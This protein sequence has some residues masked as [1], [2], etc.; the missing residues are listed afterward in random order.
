M[1]DL[2][3]KYKNTTE[4]KRS[5]EIKQFKLS[6]HIKQ[7]PTDYTSVIANELVKSDIAREEMKLEEL[8]RK[9]SIHE[10]V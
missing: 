3:N 1:K 6:Q 8:I 5:L 2:Y 9:M 4:R 10:V 7:N